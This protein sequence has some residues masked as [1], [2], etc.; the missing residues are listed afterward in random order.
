MAVV[1]SSNLIST[2]HFLRKILLWWEY[3]KRVGKIPLGGNMGVKIEKETEA[4]VL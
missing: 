4:W 3:S 2:L 1:K